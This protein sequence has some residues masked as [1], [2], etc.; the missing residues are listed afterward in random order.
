MNVIEQARQAYAPKHFP[1]R[2][3]RSV[4]AELFSQI[5]SRLKKYSID[6]KK[7]YP[8]FVTAL[9]DNRR[10]W[11]TMAADVSDSL[12]T[13][14]AALR[15]Q[16]FY[17]AEFTEIHSRKVIN[18]EATADALIDINTSILRGLNSRGNV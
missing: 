16:L 11:S 8:E 13:L 5:T 7:T 9:H 1:L 4:E 6:S 18:G 10:L 3:P 2:T 17:L 12:N 15:A 14:P